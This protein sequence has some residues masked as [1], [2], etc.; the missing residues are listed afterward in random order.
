MS[1]ERDLAAA[2]SKCTVDTLSAP[3]YP[4]TGSHS[5]KLFHRVLVEGDKAYFKYIFRFAS[6]Y[7]RDEV[8]KHV[9]KK[10]R[11]E[12]FCNFWEAT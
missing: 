10:Q 3:G 4:D 7:A 2:L 11:K 5:H 9:Y 8:F 6:N 12:L 1:N